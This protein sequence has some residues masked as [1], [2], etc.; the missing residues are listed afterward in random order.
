MADPSKLKPQ[1]KDEFSFSKA[2]LT[3]SYETSTFI[4]TR[5]PYLCAV[6][7]MV[8]TAEEMKERKIARNS[9]EHRIIYVHLG[10]YFFCGTIMAFDLLAL[11]RFFAIVTSLH[12]AVTSYTEYTLTFGENIAYRKLTR[13]IACMGC[14]LMVAGGIAKHR[15]AS[16]RSQRLISF[17][18]QIIGVYA[19]LVVVL[20][21]NDDEEF[22]A[23]VTSLPFGEVLTYVFLAL[24][25]ILG[26]CL[27]TGYKTVQC[28]KIYALLLLVITVVV[29][30]NLPYW[31]A[32]SKL[33]TW[34]VVSV[35]TRHVPIFTALLLVRR[36]YC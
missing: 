22:G 24:N 3:A 9:L 36:G 4:I 31:Q 8:T 16:D 28:S 11:K 2:L 13:N 18:R 12:L 26:T 30:A 27:Y 29:D 19:V 20:I 14:Y 21:W 15:G 10:V 5:Y 34:G 1:E 35:A 25:M 23:F 17:G 33:K 32:H 7:L 6:L